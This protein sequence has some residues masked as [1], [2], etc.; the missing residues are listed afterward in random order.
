MNKKNVIWIFSDQQ[1]AHTL[2]CN[3]NPDTKTANIDILSAQGINF[4]NAY[5]GIPLCC[6]Y[7]GS[8]LTS[9]YPH[10]CIPGHERPLPEGQKTIAHVFNDN[11][12]KTAYIGK[13]HI[14][15]YQEKNGRAAKHHIAKEKRG[16]FK[17]WLGYENNN[18]QY[19]AWIHGNDWHGKEISHYRLP[20]YE[21][22]ELTN[23][24]IEY[25]QFIA[26]QNDPFFL[27]LSVQ[28]PH[29]PYV[30]PAEYMK[31]FSPSSIQL[32]KNVPEV[33]RVTERVRR[34]LSGAYA[35]IENL[36][37][38]I[39][40]I[41]DTLKETEIY[42]D[43]HVIFFSDHGDMHGSH[44]QFRKTTCYQESV[45]VPFIISG[46]QPHYYD[47]RG[48]GIRNELLNHV[49]IAPTTL[50]LCDIE[51]PNWMKGFDYSYL[52][53]REKEIP[54]NIPDSLFLQIVIPTGHGDSIN[55]PWRG[56]VTDDGWKYA[57]FKNV[58]WT[59][60]NL[61]EDP[62]EQVNLA[63]NESYKKKRLELLKKLKQ[64]IE[65]TGDQFSLPE[66]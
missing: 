42:N 32:R 54:Q 59:M 30:A 62:Y 15:G 36:D 64:W 57:C 3:G 63:H 13:W 6:P 65:K 45:N 24:T 12:Y 5:S 1:P 60:F 50:G 39:G 9:Q 48:N 23:L 11:D 41:I 21:T 47:G 7:R 26:K 31:K 19:D 28:P 34:E 44:G 56:I 29:D 17:T 22:D 27:V 18:S 2:S 58:S 40:R 61:N 53:L 38:N 66:N 37:W 49:D 10:N 51:T 16:G 46:E 43:T 52:R 8:L 25:L 4:K 55:K 14:D 20:G 33:A 35:M